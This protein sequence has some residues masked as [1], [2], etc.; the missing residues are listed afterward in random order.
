MLPAP[1]EDN[2]YPTPH[3]NTVTDIVN[4]QDNINRN[5]KFTCGFLLLTLL[6]YIS[7]LKFL[8]TVIMIIIIIIIII[9]IVIKKY[10]II[11]NIKNKNHIL[12]FF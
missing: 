11:Y 8:I 4:S 12:Y 9:I 7:S 6:M 1:G 2:T 3:T 5:K 10:R